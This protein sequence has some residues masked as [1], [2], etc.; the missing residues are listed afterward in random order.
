MASMLDTHSTVLFHTMQL[1]EAPS[2]Q[3]HIKHNT[4]SIVYA[5]SHL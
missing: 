1:N 4:S 3:F 2:I 5:D